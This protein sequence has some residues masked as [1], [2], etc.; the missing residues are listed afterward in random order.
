[1]NNQMSQELISEL[2]EAFS[3]ADKNGDGAINKEELDTLLMSLGQNVNDAE[4]QDLI[5][6]EY[7][8]GN[9]VS[10][11]GFLTIMEMLKMR[12]KKL[13]EEI[14]DVF[15]V[16]DMDGN[17]FITAKELRQVMAALGDKP[18]D[19]EVEELMRQADIDGDG[20]VSFE[21]FVTMMTTN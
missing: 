5:N 3:L 11:P 20:Q 7:A 19:G 15:N 17:G 21:E 2:K 6:K 4:L 9:M 14:R 16:F 8:V 12:D 13:E 18:T 1:M 10:L